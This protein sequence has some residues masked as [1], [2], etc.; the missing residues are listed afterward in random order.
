MTVFPINLG[1]NTEFPQHR[2]PNEINAT[3]LT[4]IGNSSNGLPP[5]AHSFKRETS[6]ISAPKNNGHLYNNQRSHSSLSNNTTS[7]SPQFILNVNPYHQ[8]QQ[9]LL[10]Q[11]QLEQQKER[12]RIQ[13]E[14]DA[15]QRELGSLIPL[16]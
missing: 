2:N 13:F 9:Q 14:K 15:K 4:V 8:I 5:R 6:N 16:Q 1:A 10:Q 11:Q 3:T 7:I 12:D